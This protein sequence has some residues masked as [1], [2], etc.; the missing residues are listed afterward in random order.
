[1]WW[2]VSIELWY[3]NRDSDGGWRQ[4]AARHGG[5]IGVVDIEDESGRIP[6]WLKDADLL[7]GN[8]T[9]ESHRDALPVPGL[10]LLEQIGFAWSGNR[11]LRVREQ[12]VEANA[13]LYVLGTLDHRRDVPNAGQEVGLER[14]ARLLRT[15]EWRRA[16]VAAMP[17]PAR[18]P[19]AVLIGYLDMLTQVGRGGERVQ[20]AE[21]TDPP[22]IAPGARLVWKGRLGRPFV[23][24]NQPQ[25]GALDA[26]RKRSL[27]LGGLGAALLCFSVYQL[28]EWLG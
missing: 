8:Q 25:R 2:D 15:G 5:T 1:V 9:W 7:L 16:L 4:V 28:F 20:R 17:R 19:V 18:V 22:A 24:S 3:D 13:T 23:V 6:V 14:I 26:L 12:C 21:A 10:M 11:R 27:V